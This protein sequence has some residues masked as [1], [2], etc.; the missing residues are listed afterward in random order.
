M[1]HV[2]ILAGG[3]GT[4]F[5][6]LSRRSLPKQ[7]LALVGGPSLIRGTADRVSELAPP[8]RTLVVT[9][10][11]H[12]ELAR[13]ALPELPA[14]N[15]VLEPEG[16]DTAA[17]MGLA[18]VLVR[19]RDPEGVCLVLPSDHVIRPPARFRELARVALAAAEGEGALVT[20]GVRPTRPATGYGYI[21]QGEGTHPV[22][23]V[24]TFREKPD[25]ATARGFLESGDYL[26]NA[27]IF[28]WRADAIL[29]AIHR[30]LPAHHEGLSRIARSVGRADYL[31]VLAREFP[32]LPRVSVDHGVLERAEGVRVVACDFEWDDVGSWRALERHGEPDGDGNLA[33][34]PWRGERTAG[35]IVRAQPGRMVVTVGVRDLIIVDAGDAIL[36]C[37]KGHAE[38]GLKD[39]LRGVPEELR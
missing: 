39:V 7:F 4:R 22:Y 38:Q 9:G 26:W 37:D 18:A 3:S 5:W 29:E 14:A 23:S 19:A 13:Q 25:E 8:G 36:V 28:A 11:A 34:G 27:G 12:A 6:P 35:C 33:L 2:V 10:A 32:A 16:R 17:A 15:V 21:R 31:E 1:L 24:R 20:F 30:H